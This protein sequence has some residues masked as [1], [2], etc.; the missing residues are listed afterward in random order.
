MYV[1]KITVFLVKYLL[2]KS[3]TKGCSH[4]PYKKSRY[5]MDTT[6][7]TKIP[8]LQQYAVHDQQSV[9]H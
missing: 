6:A 7:V 3:I 5:E 8:M 4:R 9:S 1:P 2:V